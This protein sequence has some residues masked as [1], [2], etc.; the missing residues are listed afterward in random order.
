M[1]RLLLALSL[2]LLVPAT[3]LAGGFTT[4][5]L[6]QPP[7][8]VQAG[9]EWNATFTILQHG[10]TPLDG[11]HPVL[12][13]TNGATTEQFTATGAGEAGVY[14]ARVV[15]PR[16]GRWQVTIDHGWGVVHHFA[17]VEVGGG[18]PVPAGGSDNPDWL[19]AIGAALLAA[20][21]AASASV[22]LA[23]RRAVPA[24]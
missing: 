1:T 9:E 21:L 2:L 10:R 14:H 23:R 22:A 7:S 8:G 19:P 12:T 24:P 18:A 5:G 6:D 3:A 13:I 17:P 11:E 16:D 20:V 4:V 15:F